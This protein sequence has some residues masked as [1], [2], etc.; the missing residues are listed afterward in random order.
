MH[1]FWTPGDVSKPEWV[2]IVMLGGGIHVTGSLRFTSG[3]TPA[4]LLAASM[5]TEPFSF[6]YQQADIG[7]VR[8]RVHVFLYSI[9]SFNKLTK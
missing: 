1:H 2:A 7:G 8:N 9:R 5:A 4:D 3:V 6:T